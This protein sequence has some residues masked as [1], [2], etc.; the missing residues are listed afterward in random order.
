MQTSTQIELNLTINSINSI[1]SKD[2]QSMLLRQAKDQ[3]EK[4]CMDRQY[5][6]SIERI[7]RRSL[8]NLIRRDFDAKVRVYAI[9]EAIVIRFDKYDTIT[10]MHVNKIIPKSKIGTTDLLECSNDYCRALIQMGDRLSGFKVGDTIPIKVGEALL[11]IKNPQV[12]V[13]A[14]PFVPHKMEKV[15]YIVPKL[16]AYDRE[17]IITNLLPI[18]EAKQTEL[19]SVD[20]DKSKY[21]TK[22]LY[23]FKSKQTI[24][25]TPYDLLTL[26]T[27]LEQYEGQAIYIDQ[28]INLAELKLS[29][30]TPEQ[31][32]AADITLSNNLSFASIIVFTFAKHLDIIASLSATYLDSNM[33]DQHQYLWE[34]Y[35]QNRF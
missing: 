20:K 22:L 2:F 25:G 28:S 9:V 27:T 17:Q 16:S 15:A 24:V 12:L 14:Y 33:F 8:P 21:F 35:E 1:Y 11:K 7:V 4:K 32:E 3:Y 6:L 23:P 26:L 30:V 29:L 13:S 18:L 10:N 34:L 5:I 19:N 31:M